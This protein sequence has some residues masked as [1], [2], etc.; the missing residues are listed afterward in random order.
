MKKLNLAIIGQGRSGKDIHGTYLGS[1]HNKYFKVAYIVEEDEGRRQTAQANYPESTVL[2]DYTKLFGKGDIDLVVNCTYSHLHYRITKELLEHGMNVL[3][4]KPFARNRYECDDLINTA[5]RNGVLLAVFQ[6][7]F[8][9]PFYRHILKLLE[10]KTLGDIVQVSIRYNALARRWDWQT[11]QKMMG[12]NAYNTGPHP[13]GIALGIL[14]F[15]KSTEVVFSRL[16]NTCLF[17]GDADSYCKVLL[18]APSKPLI[19]VEIN[20]T[21][22]YSGYNV[23][24]QGTKGTFKCTPSAYEMK[25]VLTDENPPRPVVETF[26][27]DGQGKPIYCSEKLICREESGKYDGTAFDAGTRGLYEDLYFALTEG[28]QMYVTARMAQKIISV[29]ETAHAQSYLPVRF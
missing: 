20:N 10:E 2:S 6:Q 17:S 4:E 9:A 13:F 5:E 11:L 1:S 21:D 7:T 25:Y 19:D 23:K 16:E 3:V 22:A 27:H 29:I 8:Y 28:R 14:G 18:T 26:L 12:G 15:D 24:M